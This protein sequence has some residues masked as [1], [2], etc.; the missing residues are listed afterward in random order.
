MIKI[1]VRITVRITFRVR[2]SV[3]VVRMFRVNVR[4]VRMYAEYHHTTTHARMM[5]IIIE[6]ERI[7]CSVTPVLGPIVSCQRYLDKIL[8]NIAYLSD[9]LQKMSGF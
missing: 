4:V 6:K 9:V 5:Y 2:I 7:C 3:R 8:N 1:R